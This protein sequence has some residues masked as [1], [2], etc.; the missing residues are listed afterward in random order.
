MLIHLYSLASK[1]GLDNNIF[2]LSYNVFDPD[3]NMDPLV[4]YNSF[5]PNCNMYYHNV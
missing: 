1:A 4:D 2:V 3:C 5:D